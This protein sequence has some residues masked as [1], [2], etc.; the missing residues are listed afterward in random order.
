MGAKG[1]AGPPFS[2]GQA[3]VDS[4]SP[5]YGEKAGYYSAVCLETGEVEW[6]ELEGNSNGESSVA[7]LSQLQEQHPGPLKVIWDNCR[8][9]VARRCVS[10]CGRLAWS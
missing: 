3:L 7:F 4:T 2:R 10:I 6:M 5:S 1:R 8:C 9:T